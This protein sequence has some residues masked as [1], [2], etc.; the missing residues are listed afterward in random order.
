MVDSRQGNNL[1]YLPLDKLM[2][3]SA[4][5]ATDPAVVT[6]PAPPAAGAAVPV[7]PVA[8]DPRTRD[9]TRTR[10]RDNR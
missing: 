10:E 3:M 7:P 6:A 4:G 5:Q 9:A 1:L 8:A 2:Q